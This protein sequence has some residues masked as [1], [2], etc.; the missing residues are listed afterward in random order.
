MK[1]NASALSLRFGNRAPPPST[2]RGRT[3]WLQHAAGFIL[4]EDVRR[5]ALDRVEADATLDERAKEAARRAID[6]ALYGLMMSIDGVTGALE[7]SEL[8]V[9][10]RVI[11]RLMHRGDGRDELVEEIDLGEGDGMCMGYQFWRGGDFGETPVV[12]RRDE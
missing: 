9:Q 6:D 8:S 1:K 5:H 7:G 3:L 12:T 2:P 11:A 4:F 10:L